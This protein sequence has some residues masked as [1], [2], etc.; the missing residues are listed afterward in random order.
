MKQHKPKTVFSSDG[1]ILFYDLNHFKSDI[2]NG[3][4]C[5]ICG[6]KQNTKEF[7]DEHIIPNWIL[8]RFNLQEAK[9]TLPNFTKIQYSK[10]KVPCCKECNS[11]LGEHF[12]IPI[13]EL[14]S[15]S[16]DEIAKELINSPDKR[17]LLFRWLCL[18]YFKTHLKD[19]S[20]KA[21]KDLRKDEGNI[22]D[23][24]E[25]GFFHHIHCIVRSH[26][27]KAKLHED[28]YG[29]MV[30]NKIITIDQVDQ[31]DYIDNPWTSC[32]L[33]QLGEFCVAAVLD[34]S[35][36]SASIYGEQL[37]KISQGISIYQFFE[38]FSHLNFISL[39]LKERPIFQSSIT[40]TGYKIIAKIPDKMELTEISKRIGTHG[41]FLKLY[42]ERSFPDLPDR[43]EILQKIEK[44]EWTFL[45]DSEGKFVDINKK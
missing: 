10:Y 3:G 15:K 20:L 8:K 44:A 2:V 26:H 37:N 36:A 30:I 25:W 41:D 1:R 31:F 23:A 9:I 39:H 38:I 22:G 18:I 13:S 16:Y 4:C 32:V 35:C 43:D 45:W 24:H 33:L 42:A 28:V 27:T 21:S 29:S 34:D 11:Q 40:K 12:E 5:F 17:D 19:K 7:N 6:A 14:L